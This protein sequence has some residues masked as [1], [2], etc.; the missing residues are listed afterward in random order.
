M[1][2]LGSAPTDR[3]QKRR[4]QGEAAIAPHQQLAAIVEIGGVSGEKKQDEARQKLGEANVS[5]I[6]RALRDLVHLPSH[7][8]GLHLERDDDEEPRERVRDEV[9]MGEGYSP[10]KARV[11]G[12]GTEHSLLLC[13]RIMHT[14]PF[15]AE[16]AAVNE[17]GDVA[18]A[19]SVINVDYADIRGAG[20][21]HPEQSGEA[22]EG[23]A[24]TYAGWNG[25]HRNSYQAADYARHRAFHSGADYDHTRLRERSAMRQQA[26][27][28]RDS[29]VIDM[30][31][32][33][34][35]QFRGD[36]RFLGD[37]DVAGSGGHNHDHALAVSLAIALEHDGAS[38]CAIFWPMLWT[39]LCTILCQVHSG[40]DGGKLFLGSSGRQYVAAVSGQAGEDV[41]HLA[42]R[43]ALGKN[44]F[45]HTLAQGAMVVDLGETEILKGQVAKALDGFVRRETLFAD[46]LEQLAKGLGIHRRR[47][48]CRWLAVETRLAAGQARRAASLP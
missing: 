8:D 40:G 21:H 46:L 37:R 12:T 20:V 2:R 34:A 29:D 3:E 27:D 41:R 35:H 30:L 28:A 16:S 25:N 6:E 38:D 10:G 24:I 17:R 7:G 9:G 32:V 26:V 36:D 15:A 22:F 39:I 13:H 31:N 11:F 14:N 44:H 5:E 33:I 4:A 45:G 19:E 1:S 42:R 48:H 18:R 43:F 47:L 23:G